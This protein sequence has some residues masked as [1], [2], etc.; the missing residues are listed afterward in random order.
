MTGKINIKMRQIAVCV[1]PDI[2]IRVDRIAERTGRTRA[3]IIRQAL[4]NL[5][6]KEGG[7]A[8]LES[9]N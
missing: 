8:T 4:A 7:D 5:V 1:N 2:L 9:I 3:G 6:L